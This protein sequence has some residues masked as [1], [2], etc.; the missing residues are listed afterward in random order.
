MYTITLILLFIVNSFSVVSIKELIGNVKNEKGEALAD[1]NIYCGNIIPVKSEKDGNFKLIIY[2][3]KKN[4]IYFIKTG[5][6]PIIKVMEYNS[7]DELLEVKMEEKKEINISKCQNLENT[8]NS[9]KIDIFSNNIQINVPNH[10][11]IHIKRN[12][13]YSSYTIFNKSNDKTAFLSGSSG[14]GVTH[15]FP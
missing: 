3:N 4:I 7:G 6:K 1:V 8:K 14:P 15:G 12:G 2:P 9:K 10:I 13:R 11:D 5:Y